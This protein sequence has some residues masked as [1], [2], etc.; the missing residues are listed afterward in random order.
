MKHV[1]ILSISKSIIGFFLINSTTFLG[2]N[3]NNITITNPPINHAIDTYTRAQ[4]SINLKPGFKYGTI[5][6]GASNLLNLNI[7]TLPGFV[8]NHYSSINNPYLSCQ[9]TIDLT[10]VVGETEGKLSVSNTGGAVY[11][12]PIYIPPGTNNVVPKVSI[13][14]NSQSGYGAL[15][16]GWHLGAESAISRTGKTPMNDGI[17]S[18][19]EL[20][21]NDYYS[22]DGSKLILTSGAYGA[23]NSVYKSEIETYA[24]IIAHNQQGSGPQWF[25]MK[26][27]YGSRIEF[28][29][30]IYYRVVGVGNSTVLTWKLNKHTD[31]FG[32][33][34]L[35]KYKTFHGE[36]VLDK[37]EYTGNSNAGLLPYNTIEFSY[38]PLAEKST[39]FIN[40]TSF[41]KSALLKSIISRAEG[42]VARSYIFDYDW[43]NKKTVLKSITEAESQGN[44]LNRTDFCWGDLNYYAGF[45]A[46]QNGQLFPTN[47]EYM[48]L[49][50]VVPADI[51]GDGFSDAICLFENGIQQPEVRILKNV[52]KT[53]NYGT[54]NNLSFNKIY[55]DDQN[56][57]DIPDLHNGPGLI[58]GAYTIDDN[59]DNI[60]EVY[61]II[62]QRATANEY[63]IDKI[64]SNGFSGNISNYLICNN[65]TNNFNPHFSP[66]QFFFSIADYTGDGVNDELRIDP[67][68]IFLNCSQ[69]FNHQPILCQFPINT[70]NTVARPFD[71]NGD[72]ISEFITLA[73]TANSFSADINLFKLDMTTLPYS[74]VHIQQIKILMA[75]NT[76]SSRDFLNHITI[77]DFNGDG[78]NDLIYMNAFLSDLKVLY[79]NGLQLINEQTISQ[80]TTIF[81]QS[82]AEFFIRAS[83]LNQ[84]GKSDL[85]ITNDQNNSGIVLPNYFTYYFLGDNLV[86]KGPN[87][88]G[89]FVTTPLNKRFD[90][91]PC[92]NNC[93]RIK[94]VENPTKITGYKTEADYNGDG[95]FDILSANDPTT[96]QVISNN[97]TGVSN[98]AI[99]TIYTGLKRKFEIR[100]GNI[101]NEI[102]LGFGTDKAEV[103]RN[104]AEYFGP[105]SP[106][107]LSYQHPLYKYKPSMYC[108]HYLTVSSG[109]NFQILNKTKYFY[110]NAIM[111]TLGRGFLGFEK[112]HSY[113]PSTKIGSV[114]HH[115][116]QNAINVPL[117]SKNIGCVFQNVTSPL[118]S[119]PAMVVN[120]NSILTESE[121]VFTV[122]PHNNS[123][124]IRLD[125]IMNT[126][127]VNSTKS[128]TDLTYDSNG[129]GQILS[130]VL[131][132]KNWSGQTLRTEDNTFTYLLVNGHYK[133]LTSNSTKTQ[134][135]EMPYTRI[136]QF[137]Y[138][139]Q[140]HL[141]AI[142]NDPSF[143]SQSLITN[144]SQFTPFGQP[145]F[146]TLSA[147]DIASRSTQI[148]YDSKGRYIT[149][150]TNE[151]GDVIEYLLE[152]VYGNVTQK[153]GITGLV[154][155]MQY[156][157]VGR[158]VKTIL[159]NNSINKVTYAWDQPSTT[160]NHY[161]NGV[162]RLG[163]YS[164]L[165]ENESS[166]YNKKYFAGAYL[167]REETQGQTDAIVIDFKYNNSFNPAIPEGF[168][169][170]QTEPHFNS[171]TTYLITKHFYD[172]NF[173]RKN[174]S[175]IHL[176]SGN[177]YTNKNL[178]TQITLNNMS[179]QITYNN[180][181]EQVLDQSG[182][183]IIK[184]YN[185]IGQLKRVLN[186]AGSTSQVA[187]YS[188]LSH[189]E[190]KDIKLNYNNNPQNI[191]TSFTYD[192]FARQASIDDP[193]AGLI[194]YQYNTL[195]ELI[196][197][198][199]PGPVVW[200]FTYDL[201]GRLQ[202]KTGP[203]GSTNYQYVNSN[204]GK[205]QIAQIS[206]PNSVSEFKYDTY[207]GLVESKEIYGN[208]VFK[209]E[210]Q[211]DQYGRTTE[212]I[213]PSG[214][215]VKYNY[216][217]LNNLTKIT[218]NN[219][220]TIWQMGS[221]TAANEINNYS[222]GNGVSVNKVISDLH[223][224]NEINYA[225]ICKQSY[226]YNPLNGSLNSRMYER[227]FSPNLGI[228]KEKF[229]I[230]PLDRLQ[231]TEQVNPSN[232]QVIQTNALTYQTNG[233]ITHKD[234]AG[235][236]Q[237]TN[238]NSPYQITSMSNLVNNVSLNTLNFSF[239][240]IDKIQLITEPSTNNQLDFEY[241]NNGQRIRMNF[242][243]NSNVQYSRFYAEN[244]DL[245]E[246]VSGIR[247]WTYIYAPT[248][249]C[250][251]L[252]N[253]NGNKQLL[254]AITDH[255]G[256]SLA[257]MN[258]NQVVVEELS[259]DSWGRRRNSDNW[260][261]SSITL[262]GIMI[263]GYTMHEHLDAFA[264]INMNGRIYEPITG[265]FI[266]PDP[267]IQN[268]DNLQN[269]NRYAYCYNNPLKYTDPSGE[270][271]WFA[272]LI[273]AGVN[274]LF[275][276]V[277]NNFQ[278][279]GQEILISIATGAIA[280]AIAFAGA[281]LF[282]T[283]VG[284]VIASAFVGQM[285]RFLPSIPI[286]QSEN[287]NLS[288]S[289]MVGFGTSGFNFGVNLNANGQVGT[290]VYAAS[291]GAGYTS[292]VSSLGENVGGSNFYNAG[293]FAGYTNGTSTYGAG[294]SYNSFTGNSSQG[295]G[296]ITLQLDRLSIRFDEDWKI[297]DTEDRFRTGGLLLTYKVNDDITLAFGGSMLTGDG[298]KDWSGDGNGQKNK[299]YYDNCDEIMPNLRGGIM[300]GGIVYKGQSYFIGHNS[301]NRL[302][303]IQNFI[304]DRSDSPYYEDRMLRSRVY[305]HAGGYHNNFLYY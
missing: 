81:A 108:V 229:T 181:F 102:F 130:S 194:S 280:G 240:D 188:Y 277:T 27:Q 112:I 44:E 58:L 185:E 33:Y 124:I 182:K 205:N 304:H 269:F 103:Y 140:G 196:T 135:G 144:F 116:F 235:D 36:V 298:N 248:G 63:R 237:Y 84:D 104:P 274:L 41:K 262:P 255:L 2:Q 178:F 209:R 169:L 32:N 247:E 273:F 139:Q 233:N 114:T 55:D 220:N 134:T 230:D 180:K 203:S 297:G 176:L 254:Y 47:A 212:H 95:Y 218:D 98:L 217:A 201:I 54:N 25:E 293:G 244:Y 11:S 261:Y 92:N 28:G 227:F 87:Y 71:L 115:D 62:K 53:N 232:N 171:Q 200:N 126:D 34:I 271:V 243:Q 202:S 156:D 168:L 204:F 119:V 231:K 99:N 80:F 260:S 296:A 164:I 39:Y 37:I 251:V 60:Q 253:N 49:N 42:L 257:L 16:F 131:T 199:K 305:G 292:G 193:S 133:L 43:D 26:N 101:L 211:L 152:P 109:Y 64:S 177:S 93:F 266:Q 21:L 110:E 29:K 154:T 302:H 45:H 265:R 210:Y 118:K 46:S 242:I 179:T 70:P 77:G 238:S 284:Q 90:F 278:M 165:V 8:S 234:D 225:S 125:K 216:D 289:P 23:N 163:V 40:A 122:L 3:P 187:N 148:E 88:S 190:P 105:G 121:N 174:R 151:I 157:G 256:S 301:E 19:V 137:A 285:N 48:N 129:S 245:E 208:K 123:Q 73:K 89:N 198:T 299:G 286:Y 128:T 66:S 295:I 13:S 186:L 6:G 249:L 290:I 91:E 268:P 22:M 96:D 287:F 294:Y 206:G 263:R 155:R 132:F 275:D 113:D 83:D 145:R 52:L 291:V 167:L 246:T 75:D 258:A 189:G 224:V 35:Y 38:V 146:K 10:K 221:I 170:E 136:Q 207:G 100:Y 82:F 20:S 94:I 161:K 107:P 153:T 150:E 50:T 86:S 78:N 283:S 117:N 51:D 172:Q 214:F 85:I 272:P 219:N 166:P 222:L 1:N 267:Y 12:I 183:L 143:G 4:V 59:F 72:G 191:T 14:Y 270:F 142:T 120:T 223:Y 226:N 259:F 15:G 7:S 241:G 141:T 276:M 236:Y 138:D 67:E 239:N 159:P 79:S 279:S 147:G 18:S 76:V 24:T 303:K 65:L 158:L 173:Y 31:E 195:G 127:Y 228:L 30:S 97:T 9:G 57:F 282:A 215:K 56:F 288:I 160:Y 175:E 17:F 111:H 162:A 281:P 5:S 213:Y 69:V 252:Y 68:T 264:L 250:A 192:Q 300:Y 184:E 149:K 106:P 74:L 61:T 197:E